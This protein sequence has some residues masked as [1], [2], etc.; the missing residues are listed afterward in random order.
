MFT[1][2]HTQYVIHTITGLPNTIAGH[3][4]T[5]TQLRN[6][7]HCHILGVVWILLVIFVKV[8]MI[9]ILIEVLIVSMIL[10]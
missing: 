4:T 6:L 10:K 3:G 1:C 9:M 7:G 5:P 8:I 2:Y